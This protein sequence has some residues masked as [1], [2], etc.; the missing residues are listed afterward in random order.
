LKLWQSLYALVWLSFFSLLSAFFEAI[1]FRPYVHAALGVAMVALAVRNK[2]KLTATQAPAR[3]KRICVVTAF[4][5][6]LAAMTGV[7]LGVH[8]FAAFRFLLLVVHV[9]AAA[10]IVAQSGSVAT[11]Y[12]M[13]EEREFEDGR[14]PGP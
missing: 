10:A 7:L 4:V 3:L 8:D 12:D 6:V 9:T 5:A 11:A 13:W 1:P 14:V 2:T